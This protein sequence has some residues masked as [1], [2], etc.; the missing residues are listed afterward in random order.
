MLQSWIF[1]GNGPFNSKSPLDDDTV[2]ITTYH[3]ATT[4][5]Q[6]LATL[7]PTAF[8]GSTMMTMPVDLNLDGVLV[9][10]LLTKNGT[11]TPCSFVYV[12]SACNAHTTSCYKHYSNNSRWKLWTSAW[13]LQKNYLHLCSPLFY[14]FYYLPSHK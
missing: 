6:S 2:Q 12:F 5:A 13:N 11:E 14:R 7:N 1:A 9:S 10:F 3:F 8:M 4:L